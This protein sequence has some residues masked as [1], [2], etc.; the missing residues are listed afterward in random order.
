LRIPCGS[1]LLLQLARLL[2]R[3]DLSLS[4]LCQKLMGGVKAAGSN[5]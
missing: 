1:R 5:R 2:R 4:R 3:C